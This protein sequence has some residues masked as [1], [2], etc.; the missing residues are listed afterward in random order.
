MPNITLLIIF[1]YIADL[2]FGDPEWLPHPVRIMGAL[3]NFLDKH[4][5]KSEESSLCLCEEERFL[6]TTKQSFIKLKRLLRRLR[7]LAMTPLVNLWQGRI[8]GIIL[9]VIVVGISTL[10]TR[11]LIIYAQKINIFLGAAVYIYF[12][13]ASLAVKDLRCK[14]SAVL[15]GL[16]AG[17]LEEARLKLSFIV[18]R[19]TQNL[20]E[21]KIAQATIESVAENTSD[22]IV[23]PLFYLFLGGPVLA[24]SYKAVNTLD[25][26]VGYKNKRYKDFGWCAAKLDDL[27]NFIPARLTGILIAISSFITGKDFKRSFKIMLRDGRN[28]DSPNSGISEAAM[29]GAINVQLGGPSVYHGEIENKPYI[30]DNINILQPELISP[31][32]RISFIVSLL[33]ILLGIGARWAL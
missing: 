23:A 19:D 2:I 13:Y 1:S 25:S 18:G 32:L 10:M 26:M 7:L 16:K 27:A 9:V 6:A 20:S 21:E 24:I 22:G 31:A 12:G 8:R 33:V 3:I 29:A 4:L 17:S 15:K 5:N 11:A 28:H 30:G 14:A